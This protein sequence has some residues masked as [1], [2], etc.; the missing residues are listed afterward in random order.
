[1]RRQQKKALKEAFKEEKKRADRVNAS[2]Q[3]GG[4]FKVN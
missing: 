4:V 3:N 2:S 1:M